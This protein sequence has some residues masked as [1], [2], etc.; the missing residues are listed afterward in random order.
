MVDIA[1][2]LE[3]ESLSFQHP[4]FA[5]EKMRESYVER[6]GDKDSNGIDILGFTYE[7]GINVDALLEQARIIESRKSKLKIYFYPHLQF[8]KLHHYYDSLDYEFKK[9]CLTPWR[10][11][12]VT[13]TGDIGPCVHYPLGNIT[14]DAF[15]TVWN[16]VR[17]KKFRNTI[18]KR[19]LFSG[20]E[21]CCLREY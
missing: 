5:N 14:R 6:K 3:A 19:G 10:K 17:Y 16:S 12:M 1:E 15:K 8:E 4:M 11:V 18:K 7:G 9:I 20:C 21:R 2:E 13:P